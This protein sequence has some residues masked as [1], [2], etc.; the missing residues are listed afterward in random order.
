MNELIVILTFAKI[1]QVL[2]VLTKWSFGHKKTGSNNN[3]A[4][5]KNQSFQ[6]V[7]STILYIK[8]ANQNDS[9]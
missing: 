7:R 5:Q 3:V 6:I 2:S 4:Q 1:D 8:Q 9:D